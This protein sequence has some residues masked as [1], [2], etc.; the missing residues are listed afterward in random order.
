MLEH[1]N[2]P[3][4]ASQFH[5]EKPVFEF[6]EREGLQNIPHS[7]EAI[8]LSGVMSRWLV[9][10]ARRNN[11][12]FANETEERQA[13]IYDHVPTVAFDLYSHYEPLYFFD[14]KINFT[15]L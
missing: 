13:L 1:R 14:R 3:I 7:S 6:F 11:H 15:I 2:F 4:Y 9:D 12:S 5:P 8:R 10:Q